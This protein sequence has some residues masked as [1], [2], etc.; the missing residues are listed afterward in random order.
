M[1]TPPPPEWEGDEHDLEEDDDPG[2]DIETLRRRRERVLTILALGL[3]LAVSVFAAFRFLRVPKP[4]RRDLIAVTQQT[5]REAPALA[6][7]VL[8]FSESNEIEIRQVGDR[9]EV[10]GRVFAIAPSGRSSTYYSFTCLLE[11]LEGRQA[12]PV[13]LVLT[14]LN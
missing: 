8:H 9:Y 7:S 6:G 13:T 10:A 11:Q 14:P 5:V 4:Q 2:L 3:I 12:R 1:S